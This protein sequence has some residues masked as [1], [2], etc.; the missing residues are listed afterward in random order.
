[1]R[2]IIY[3]SFASPDLDRVEMFR[4][5]YQARV[6]NEARGLGGFLVHIDDRILQVLEGPTWK[7][8]ATFENIRRDP[9]HRCVEVLDERLI[10]EPAF[11]GW[12]MRYFDGRNIPGMLAQMNE[13]AGGDVPRLVREAVLDFLGPDLI[14][15]I[16]E[17]FVTAA[18]A[19]VSPSLSEAAQP[20][21]PRPC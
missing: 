16:V 4:L 12:R 5:V 18:P 17:S 3:R 2:R 11:G 21:S 15:P 9:R 7:L 10:P 14:R 8:V 19:G 1:L 6:A 13:G 20:S